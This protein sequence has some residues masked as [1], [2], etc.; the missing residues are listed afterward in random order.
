MTKGS[1]TYTN[2]NE[3]RYFNTCPHCDMTLGSTINKQPNNK[4]LVLQMRLHYKS[5]HNLKYDEKEHARQHPQI[6]ITNDH[7]KGK[8]KSIITDHNDNTTTNV[9]SYW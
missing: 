6:I 9:I 2:T 5:A 1:K 8:I 3:R 4:R 7:V